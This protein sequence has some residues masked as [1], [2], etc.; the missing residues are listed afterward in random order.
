MLEIKRLCNGC[1]KD[2]TDIQCD[3]DSFQYSD[4]LGY[5]SIADG[6]TL[7]I[8]LCNPCLQSIIKTF[9]INPIS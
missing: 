1:T 6:A 7:R 5:G 4:S 3:E 8:D 2:I 9:K